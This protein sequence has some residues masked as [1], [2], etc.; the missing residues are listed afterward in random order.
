MKQRR[1]ISLEEETDSF[2][3]SKENASKYI[4]ELIKADIALEKERGTVLYRWKCTGCAIHIKALGKPQEQGRCP[5]CGTPM[6]DHTETT[7][8]R[9]GASAASA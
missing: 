7:R 3:N 2:L 1:Q 4:E 5:I 8:T 6:P 9:L